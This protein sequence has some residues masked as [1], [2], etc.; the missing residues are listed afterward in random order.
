MIDHPGMIAPLLEQMQDQLAIPAFPTTK[1]VR[2]LRR[3]G[4]EGQH[5]SCPLHRARLLCG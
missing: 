4:G 3:G 2:V 5:Q 1:I